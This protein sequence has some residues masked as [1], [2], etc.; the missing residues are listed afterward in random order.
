MDEEIKKAQAEAEK[1]LENIVSKNTLRYNFML[2]E[3]MKKVL[4]EKGIDW[5][6]KEEIINKSID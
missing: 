5:E 3:E 2:H 4:K 1:R 6:Y